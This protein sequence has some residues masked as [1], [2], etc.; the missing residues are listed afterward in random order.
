MIKVLKAFMKKET[1]MNGIII[2]IFN[3]GIH[4]I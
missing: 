3:N 4:Q 2:K 1:K